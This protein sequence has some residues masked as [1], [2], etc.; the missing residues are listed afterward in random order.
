MPE[1]TTMQNKIIDALRVVITSQHLDVA[2]QP[3]YANTGTLYAQ[4]GFQTLLE[5][6]YRFNPDY[7]TLTVRG[8]AV[9]ANHLTQ[10]PR[11][12][13]LDVDQRGMKLCWSYLPYDEGNTITDMLAQ[14]EHLL[15]QLPPPPGPRTT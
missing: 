15:R 4:R 6:R 3:Q 9:I 7:L 10:Q 13:S 2:Q 1:I 12:F 5:I 8:P 14:L 11:A